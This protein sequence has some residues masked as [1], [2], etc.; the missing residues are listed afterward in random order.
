MKKESKYTIQSID[1]FPELVQKDYL[2]RV[3]KGRRKYYHISINGRTIY[4][5]RNKIRDYLKN[6]YPD[7]KSTDKTL[8]FQPIE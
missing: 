3:L 1:L 7:V 2:R 6:K 4:I 5:P 8:Q